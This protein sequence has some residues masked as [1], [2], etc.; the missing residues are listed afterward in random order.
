MRASHPDSHMMMVTNT[1]RDCDPFPATAGTA[2]RRFITTPPNG[3]CPCLVL[4]RAIASCGRGI[5]ESV[6][7]PN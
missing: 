2:G 1:G 5:S 4:V 3:G 7:C 6:W